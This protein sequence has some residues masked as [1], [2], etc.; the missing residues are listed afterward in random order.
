MDPHP[1]LLGVLL[2]PALS[3]EATENSTGLSRLP[4]TWDLATGLAEVASSGRRR[5]LWVEGGAEQLSQRPQ[6]CSRAHV[7]VTL[8]DKV[9]ELGQCH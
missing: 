2:R 9:E 5:G 7:R 1:P 8:T 4:G 6:V 3:P